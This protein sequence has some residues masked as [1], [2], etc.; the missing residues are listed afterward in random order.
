MQTFIPKG[1]IRG[2]IMPTHVF[3]NHALGLS[4]AAKVLYAV[5]CNYAAY[6]D[7]CW[8]SQKTLA[9]HLGYS[10]TTIK[11]LI[12]ELEKA[13]LIAKKHTGGTSIYYMLLPEGFEM[14]SAIAPKDAP[15]PP[16]QD[17]AQPHFAFED[18][19][20][21]QL[22]IGYPQAEI[23]YPQPKVGYIN[24]LN[25]AKINKHSLNVVPMPN[26][27]ANASGSMGVSMADFEKVWEAYPKKRSKGFARE[28]W[29]Q[30]AQSGE[31]PPTEILLTAIQH[32]AASRNWQKEDG[33]FIPFLGKWLHGQYWL[34]VQDTIASTLQEDK[35]H[36]LQQEAYKKYEAQEHQERK[37]AQ[38]KNALLRPEFERFASR[39]SD[40][41]ADK[42]INNM[43]FGTWLYLES[44]GKAPRI[45]DVP[46]DNILNIKD[47]IEACKRG[48][49][50]K[51]HSQPF[52]PPFH[53]QKQ[54]GHFECQ[55]GVA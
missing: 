44:I 50:V 38:A 55:K 51:A 40:Y 29:I 20:K 45:S 27:K 33:R 43:L 35:R 48:Y 1:N 42:P 30:L 9:K 11:K 47:F 32:F 12:D 54:R 53:S 26:R 5:F 13:K 24:N 17:S 19:P 49:R 2:F 25:T 8:P 16:Q 39:F 3:Y 6:K 21:A 34:D 18:E 4:L 28:A 37:A 22:E 7:H 10:V 14:P 23:D 52:Q 31:L 36:L 46:H 41:H 15:V